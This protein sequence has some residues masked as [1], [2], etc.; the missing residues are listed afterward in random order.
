MATWKA[1]AGHQE[2]Q[3]AFALHGLDH[4]P[5]SHR[6]AGLE[7][8]LTFSVLYWLFPRLYNT[9]L[10]SVK[11]ANYHFWIALLGMM[12]YVIPMYIAGITEGM[13]WKQFTKDGFLQYPNF[14]E[15]VVQIIPMYRCAPSAARSISLASG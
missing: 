5:R 14:L 4:R 3:F 15:T 2:R 7:R 13:M 9:K 11:L 10:W 12:F 1:R 8:I 6:R